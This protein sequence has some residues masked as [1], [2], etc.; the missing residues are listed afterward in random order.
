MT[1]RNGTNSSSNLPAKT[2]GTSIG[3]PID[4]VNVISQGVDAI[5]DISKNL[6]NAYTAK[7]AYE[8]IKSQSKAKIVESEESN[9]TARVESDNNLKK[10]QADIQ[11]KISKI[12]QEEKQNEYEYKQKKRELMN[13]EIKINK[14]HE[15][16]ML[17]IKNKNRTHSS[18]KMLE[19]D[20]QLLRIQLAS[21]TLTE[22]QRLE[23]RK[24]MKE[25]R[26]TLLALHK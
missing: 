25:I 17:E 6:S 22:E 21:N 3:N 15:A 13:E 16:K 2:V 20:Y 14:D 4:K 10:H 11:E 23:V 8:S 9:R 1:K 19:D 5:A 18:I 24:E 26:E 7:Q 12:K